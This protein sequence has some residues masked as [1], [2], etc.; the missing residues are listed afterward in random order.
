MTFTSR[1][2][3]TSPIE[4]KTAHAASIRADCIDGW[5]DGPV[6]LT[7]TVQVDWMSDEFS[8][9]AQNRLQLKRML[10]KWAPLSLLPED[11]G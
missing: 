3:E 7:L 6:E 5:V 8:T 9:M 1:T 10:S 2:A 4:H 11:W